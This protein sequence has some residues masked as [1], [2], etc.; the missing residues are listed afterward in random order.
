MSPGQ[1]RETFF[2]LIGR[3]ELYERF[4][5]QLYWDDEKAELF[6]LLDEA[7][8]T[9]RRP[10]NGASVSTPPD[11]ATRRCAI[12]ARSS[13]T[14][15]SGTT[16]IWPR[17][18]GPSRR[19]VAAPVRFSDDARRSRLPTAPELGQ[20]TEEVLLELGYTWDDIGRLHEAGAI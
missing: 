2:E 8:A 17:S 9:A 13:P 1:A 19:A 7:F 11:C 18:T 6:P 4:P 5:E 10:P 12:T 20:H 14:P 15:T 16:A 3:P